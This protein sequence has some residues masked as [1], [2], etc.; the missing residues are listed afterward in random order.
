M[1][2]ENVAKVE[3]LRD[4]ETGPMK[5]PDVHLFLGGIKGKTATGRQFSL[6]GSL[7][8]ST[9]HTGSARPSGHTRPATQLA[10]AT[11]YPVSHSQ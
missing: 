8:R 1:Y 6:R 3:I 9:S 10:P 4:G 2:G 11:R 5:L 7:R